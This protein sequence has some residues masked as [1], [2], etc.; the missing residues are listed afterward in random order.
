MRAIKLYSSEIDKHK[1]KK[2]DQNSAAL[3]DRDIEHI[4]AALDVRKK[5]H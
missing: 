2:L 1:L 5:N 4:L 3:T